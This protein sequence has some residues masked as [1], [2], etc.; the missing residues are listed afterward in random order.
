MVKKEPIFNELTVKV[1]FKKLSSNQN[2]RKNTE[3]DINRAFNRNQANLNNLSFY[4]SS[5]TSSSSSSSIAPVL[6]LSTSTQPNL[7]HNSSSSQPSLVSSKDC[8]FSNSLYSGSTY[9]RICHPL[10]RP[11]NNLENNTP[12]DSNS[13]YN[14]VGF[15]NNPKS[16]W[17][18]LA[19]N[20]GKSFQNSIYITHPEEESDKGDIQRTMEM[21]KK[22]AKM[23][24]LPNDN[25]IDLGPS[26]DKDMLNGNCDDLLL[27]F[28][29]LMVEEKIDTKQELDCDTV[30]RC[31]VS[32]SSECKNVYQS[33]AYAVS[34][35]D[36]NQ[37]NTVNTIENN[38]QS[39]VKKEMNT[40]NHQFRVRPKESRADKELNHFASKLCQIRSSFNHADTSTNLGYVISSTLHCNRDD[41]LS[42]KLKIE[43][44][45][46]DTPIMFTCNVNTSVEHVICHA[47][48]TIFEDSSKVKFDEFMLKVDSLNE[49]LVS[50]SILGNYA[51]IHQCHMFDEDVQLTLI[52]TATNNPNIYA[53]I[54]KDDESVSSICANK[55]IPNASICRFGEVNHDSVNILL[56]TLEKEINK[57]VFNASQEGWTKCIKGVCQATKA[58]CSLLS[59]CDTLQVTEALENVSQLS[60]V[61]DKYKTKVD[62][63][64]LSSEN[65][66]SIHHEVFEHAI[67]K[68]KSSVIEMIG[69][70]CQA[71]PVDFVISVPEKSGKDGV[72]LLTS[73]MSETF[74]CYITTVNNLH[75]DWRMKH[76]DFY[77]TC[78]VWFGENILGQCKTNRIQISHGLYPRL[79]FN[80]LLH[81]EF[82]PISSLPRES[83]VYF[84]LYGIEIPQSE[85]SSSSDKEVFKPIAI[86]MLKLLD[87]EEKLTQG[88][89]LLGLW[90]GDVINQFERSAF[91][92]PCLD[93][94]CPLIIIDLP[95]YG[96]T[97][98]FPQI[99]MKSSVCSYTKQ[100]LYLLDSLT[101]TDIHLILNADPMQ[102][103]TRTDE[104][105]LWDRRHYL[106][107]VP[108]ALPKVLKSSPSWRW[109]SLHDIYSIV[110]NWSQ[111]QAI[112]AMQLLL[113][114]FPDKFVR[115]SATEWISNLSNDEICDYLPQLIQALRY[116]LHYDSPLIWF[117]LKKA[118]SSVRVAHNLYWLL[119]QNLDDPLFSYRSRIFLNAL[120]STCGESLLNLFE[121]QESLLVQLSGASDH[122]KV[123]KD[124]LRLV[125]LWRDL[126][127]V[128]DFL[129][130]NKVTLPLS[131]SVTVAEIDIKSCSY[132]TSNTLPLRLSFK[133]DQNYSS[134]N[135][136]EAIYKVGDDLRQDSLTM[137]MVKIM[138]KLWLKEGLD[139]KI[140][141]F[142]CIATDVRKGFVQIV[143]NAETLRK[144]QTEYGITGSFKDCCIAEW[145]QKYNTS[146]LEYQQAV[147]NFTYSLAGYVVATY[148]L[149]IGDRHNDN[150][151][152]TTSGHLFHIDFG[153]YLGDAQMLGTIKRDRTPFILTSDMAYVING[154]D[155]PTK[156]FQYFIDFCCQAFN[157]IRR[158]TNLFLNLFSLMVSSNIPGLSADAVKYIHRT[159]LPSLTEAEA[160]SAFNKMIGESL[161]SV[162]TK[163]N[164]FLHNL[165]QLRFTGDHNDQNMLSFVP[166][167]YSKTSDGKIVNL[168]VEDFY[169]KSEPEKVYYY[170]I[171]VEREHQL[172]STHVYRSYREFYEFHQKLSA[173]F[174][175]VKLYPLN[176]GS[177]FI[178]RSNT[179]E[180]AE[181]RKSEIAFF[182]ISLMRMSEE[183][184]KSD[185]VYTFFH[186]LLRDQEAS[187][188]ML[189]HF[190]QELKCDTKLKE[191]RKGNIPCSSASSTIKL[192]IVHKNFD[193]I[194]MIMHAKNLQSPRSSD[195][196]C[197]V[198]T[199]LL[200]DPNKLTKRKTKV[201]PKSTHPTFMEMIIYQLSREEAREKVLEV[202][203]W[204][205]DRVSENLYLGRTLIALQDLDLS[206]ETVSWYS[207][208]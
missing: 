92:T 152:I 75:F 201:V 6:S 186:P 118:Y 158:H 121:N 87:F 30:D 125:T 177:T 109:S 18:T 127:P 198:K 173:L 76:R 59:N 179:R 159:L 116:E 52:N 40:S 19:S 190:G 178:G 133:S 185:I 165:A 132:F 170:K 183:I 156:H 13:I 166:K 174:P 153:K 184:F 33:V 126:E 139:L 115:K 67:S 43:T 113:P 93:K 150:I 26:V 191:Y 61:Y 68:L 160:T 192:S 167:M 205:Y 32:S 162:S 199:Y 72:Q 45:L 98:T 1:P 95:D 81:F 122:L 64:K 79:V 31:T 124:S 101:Q 5:S 56:E 82:L 180:V 99:D 155:K 129:K 171:R 130:Q 172:D 119:K 154:G 134:N 197:Y 57:L 131:P 114:A 28:D 10:N 137:Q 181:K 207:L 60:L 46:L 103:M 107:E 194:V 141:T 3:T 151:M 58:L 42:V 27:L 62:L 146:E 35:K 157:I 73:E 200:P 145:L 196:Y 110:N 41:S 164:F 49:Y 80:E 195:P 66:E 203:V 16:H 11:W 48:C 123:T 202:S 108:S 7:T 24:K 77:I 140:V 136:I 65:L 188:M 111:L 117:L 47:V 23:E 15:R 20:Q 189:A 84:T 144:I 187:S 89:V 12:S 90:S 22:I 148:I 74:F 36:I 38:N 128:N 104:T 29:P 78:E 70:Y 147:D 54:E 208:S 97:I 86:T 39:Q 163:F 175:L 14:L 4:S 44:N 63:S 94:G 37:S 206:T 21:I 85:P 149:G 193:L 169:K 142:D 102:K 143:K 112:D 135:K 55:L 204:E 168:E 17:W 69:L 100:D 91:T 8:S 71:L 120:L 50:G 161:S 51:Y 88:S 9:G 106:Y 182:L 2:G 53:R 83:C 138:D 176:R 34:S 105:L 25:L 96:S